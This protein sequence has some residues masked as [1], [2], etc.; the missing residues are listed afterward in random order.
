MAS[1]FKRGFDFWE[2]QVDGAVKNRRDFQ[3][4]WEGYIGAA[5]APFYTRADTP[6]GYGTNWHYPEARDVVS[7]LMFNDP[8]WEA[9]NPNPEYA[10]SADALEKIMAQVW[11][12]LQWNSVMRVVLYY[13]YFT[14]FGMT[15]LEYIRG[16]AAPQQLSPS[17]EKINEIFKALRSSNDGSLNGADLAR[18]VEGVG[19]PVYQ[20]RN[21]RR[22]FPNWRRVR[23]SQALWDPEVVELNLGEMRWAGEQHWLPTEFVHNTELYDKRPRGRVQAK[24]RS[25]SND[26]QFGFGFQT[27]NAVAHLDDEWSLITEIYDFTE[28]KIITMDLEDRITLREE[29]FEDVAPYDFLSWNPLPEQR[30]PLPDASLV[31]DH[32]QDKSQMRARQRNI[33]DTWRQMTTYDSEMIN[34]REQLAAMMNGDDT[35]QVPVTVPQGKKL[36]DAMHHDRSIPI[37]AEFAHMDAQ[38]SADIARVSGLSNTR[39]GTGNRSRTSA[40]ESRALELGGDISLGDKILEVNNFMQRHGTGV[41]T[42]IRQNWSPTLIAAFSGERDNDAET[43][44]YFDKVAQSLAAGVDP[45]SIPVVLPR[46]TILGEHVVRPVS[47]SMQARDDMAD[48]QLNNLK[49]LAMLQNPEVSNSFAARWFFKRIGIRGVANAMAPKDMSGLGE[50]QAVGANQPGQQPVQ[51]EAVLGPNQGAAPGLPGGNSGGEPQLSLVG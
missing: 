45:A 8:E 15:R 36:Q 43:R 18:L 47:G 37:P 24:A 28:R 41:T 23:S 38:L 10:S 3:R 25:N 34:D 49:Y 31:F 33:M 48:F 22:G 19:D 21:E 2:S 1:L 12:D 9:V 6:D 35:V 29:P 39:R 16:T 17:R 32:A 7:N 44:E 40:F 13:A 27:R 30:M 51:P 20:N 42:L 4:V 11:L 50:F 26:R 46:M 14:G 5:G